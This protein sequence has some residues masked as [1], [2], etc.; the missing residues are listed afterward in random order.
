MIQPRW[1][2]FWHVT[3]MQLSHHTLWQFISERWTLQ[4]T[5]TCTRVF[6]TVVFL[7]AKNWKQPRI[8]LADGW[9]NKLQYF[10]TTGYCCLVA[11]SCLTLLRLHGLQPTKLLCPQGFPGK[12]TGVSCH[13]LLQGISLTQGSNLCLHTGRQILY[14]WATR[15][16]HHRILLSNKNKEVLINATTWIDFEG[17]KSK[18]T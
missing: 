6:I 11:K 16:A 3:T 13:M 2:T 8:L 15:E 4:C 18:K 9:L 17:V 7:I 12:N 1:K 10:H 5:Q 14:H